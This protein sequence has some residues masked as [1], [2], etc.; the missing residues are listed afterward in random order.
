MSVYTANGSSVADFEQCRFRWVIKWVMNRVPRNESPA[1]TEG[2]LLHT[3]FEDHLKGVRPMAD[4]IKFRC[5][6]ALNTPTDQAGRD[7]IQRAV[8]GIMDRAEALVL[9]RDQYEWEIPVLEVEEPFEIAHPMDPHF[10]LKG[11]PDRVGVMN[12]Q[13]WHIQNRG[14]AAAMNFGVYMELATRHRHEHL[15]ALAISQKYPQYPYGGTFMNLV[16]KLKYRTNVGK[17]NEAVKTLDQMFFQHPLVIDLKGE[18]HEHVML[19]LL[20]HLKEMERVEK[21]FR[22][23]GTMPSPN[24]KLNGGFNGSMIDPFFR[25]LTGKSDVADNRL[26]KDREDTYAITE[27]ITSE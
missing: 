6:E 9:W 22:E 12:G 26:W 17:N 2:K 7:T 1:L 10:H 8:D 24:E 21:E 13:L 19:S 5:A 14:L 4:A 25:L 15:Y 11:R 3:I 20:G 18:L 16:R 27:E 23:D